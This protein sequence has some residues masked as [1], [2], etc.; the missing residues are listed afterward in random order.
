MFEIKDKI[1]DGEYMIIMD[2]LSEIYTTYNTEIIDNKCKC[3]INSNQFCINNLQYFINC[4]NLQYTLACFPALRNLLIIFTLPHETLYT[5]HHFYKSHLQFEP[6]NQEKIYSNAQYTQLISTIHIFINFIANLPEKLPRC[7]VI[8]ELYSYMFT[9]FNI[10]K[11]NFKFMYTTYTKLIELSIAQTDR[12]Y[13][14]HVVML[15]K[16]YNIKKLPFTLFKDNMTLF[17]QNEIG[18]ESNKAQYQQLLVTNPICTHR[19]TSIQQPIPIPNS[20]AAPAV[21]IVDK[22]KRRAQRL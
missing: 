2:K 16:L 1:K 12:L 15:K 8:I 11:N 4:K 21:I 9:N 13:S 7:F 14:A 10:F 22:R 20:G 17:Y 6:I 18:K 5:T 19:I 3:E